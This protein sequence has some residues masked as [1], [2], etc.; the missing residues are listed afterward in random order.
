MNSGILSLTLLPGYVEDIR[1]VE[2]VPR[3][4][5]YWNALPMRPGDVL[6]LRHIEQALENFKR[7]PLRGCQHRHRGPVTVPVTVTWS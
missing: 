4:A 1:F 6:N 7:V 5:T 3:R 2:G